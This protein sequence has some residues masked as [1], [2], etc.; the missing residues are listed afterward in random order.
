MKNPSR[1]MFVYHLGVRHA[2]DFFYVDNNK[3]DFTA[4]DAADN[5]GGTRIKAVQTIIDSND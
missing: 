4:N 1:K 2:F 3:F 5:Q